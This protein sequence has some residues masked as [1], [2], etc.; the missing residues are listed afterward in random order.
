ME[1][2]KFPVTSAHAGIRAVFAGQDFSGDGVLNAGDYFGQV[3]GIV[4]T[5]GSVTSEVTIAVRDYSGSAITPQ[6]Y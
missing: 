3:A 6:K 4:I 5:D 1:S 2:R